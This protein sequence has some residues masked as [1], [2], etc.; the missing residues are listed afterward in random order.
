M[1]PSLLLILIC[2]A[3]MIMLPTSYSLGTTAAAPKPKQTPHEEMGEYEGL[4]RE[5]KAAQDKMNHL[6]SDDLKLAQ[7]EKMSAEERASSIK[8]INDALKEPKEHLAK[9]EKGKKLT[10]Q[11]VKQLTQHIQGVKDFLAADSKKNAAKK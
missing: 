9:A 7:T 2:T 10:S 6:K 5:L 4:E 1:K 11:H 3:C 8:E